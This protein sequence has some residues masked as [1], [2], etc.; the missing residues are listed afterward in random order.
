MVQS[1]IPDAIEQ[2]KAESLGLALRDAEI[3][4]CGI[5]EPDKEQEEDV[6][7]VLV[8]L[9]AIVDGL[10]SLRTHKGSAHGHEQRS[11]TMK[12]RHARLA[13]H[14]A[15]TFATFVLETWRDRTESRKAASPAHAN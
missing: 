10:G 8:G 11:Y 15:F 14:A 9:G 13:S 4:K 3:Y 6:R 2:G 12:P 7:T 1:E 5:A